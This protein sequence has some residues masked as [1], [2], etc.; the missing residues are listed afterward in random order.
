MFPR[1]WTSTIDGHAM[2]V[3]AA[4][5]EAAEKIAARVLSKRRR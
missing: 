1:S 4:T 3:V 5:G 2:H